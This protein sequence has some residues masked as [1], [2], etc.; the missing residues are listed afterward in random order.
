MSGFYFSSMPKPK[1]RRGEVVDDISHPSPVSST[2][3]ISGI[4]VPQAPKTI[5]SSSSFILLAPEMT[6]GVPSIPFSTGPVSSSKNVRQ[7]GKKKVATDSKEEMSMPGKRMK[8]AE[9]SRRTGWDRVR[10]G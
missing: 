3:F 5:V 8:D 4:A 10:P 6:S 1:I 7:L 2:A 9:D